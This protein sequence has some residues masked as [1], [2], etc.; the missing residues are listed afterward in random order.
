MIKRIYYFTLFFLLIFPLLLSAQTSPEEF[1]GHKVGADCKLADYNQ[2][3]AY[4]QTL[5]KESG[6]IKVLTIGKTTLN[7]PMIMAVITS[8]ENMANLDTYRGINKKLR[9]ARDLTPDDASRLAK[10]GK[11]TVFITCNLH[12]TEIGSSQMAMEFAYKL[13]TGKT[14]FDADK[15]LEDVIILIAP[16]INPDGQQMVTDWY[17]KY[18]GT[19]YEGGRMP[20]LYQHYAGHDN[21]RDWFMLNLAET[22]AVTKVL[23]QDW[24]P[25]IHIDQH[26]MGATGARLWIPPFAN[27]PN[28]NVHPLI[29]R[30]VAL[31]GMNMAYDL[32]KN[33][34]KGVQYGSEFAGWWDGACDNTPWFHNTICLLSEAASV[35]VASPIN[36]DISEISESYLEKSM[37]FPDP[38][39]GG[40]WR[41]RDIV[42]YELTLSMSLIKTAYLYKKELLYDF[43]KMGKDSI[44]KGGEGLPFAFVISK[45][46]NDYPTT[47]RMLDTLMYAGVEINQA[48]EDF[49][50]GDKVYPAG[51]FV[52]LMSQPYR[53][54][55]QALLE[56]QNHPE[57]KRQYP[58]GPF[59]SLLYDNAGWTLPLQMGVKCDQINNPFKANL[60]KLDKIPS[61]SITPPPETASFVILDSRLNNSY[62]VVFALFQENAEIYRSQDIIKGEGFET[63]AGSFIIKN[64]PQVQKALPDL[65]E[66][67]Q[68]KA[69]TLK[70]IAEIPKAPVKRYRVGLYQSWRS[71]MD[72]GWTRYVFDDLGIPF[73]TLHNKDFKGTKKVNLKTK[74][75]VIVFSDESADIIKL[76]K[77]NPTSRY[78]RYYRK[79]PPKYEGGIG[80]E[81]VEALK[82]FV[83]QGGI[84]VTLNSACGLAFNEFQVPAGNAIENIDRSK[85]F[86]PGSILKVKVDNK[87]PIGY[88]MPSEAAIMFYESRA[89]STRVP[90]QGWD[91]KVVARFPENDILL[92]GWLTGEDVIAR[93][94]AVVDIQR[95]KGHIILIGFPCQHRAQSHGTYKFLLNALLYPEIN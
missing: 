10:E 90:P 47:L 18:V 41:M 15:V 82:T 48:K 35:K 61:P 72:E 26:E 67:W 83:E 64:T 71:N 36:I 84:L 25:Q 56:K 30:G 88:G 1:L 31:F 38:W 70:D 93:K 91:R 54:Y 46:Q 34:F 27:P 51:S 24:V 68:V 87:T 23:Y 49:I 7:K 58:N 14:P 11:V 75:D 74:F 12:A 43:Y 39:P 79:P 3:Q 52:I 9:D 60:T 2:I 86:C 76:G 73:T 85:F 62:S 65:L 55:A 59:T 89:L 21:N 8:E 94:A 63:A 22:K 20:W 33:G 32:Q 19:K 50:V 69:D 28:P 17:R 78:A 92:S 42:D 45:K 95:K 80:E 66:K 6:K 37:Q 4:F 13:V 40:L 44:E 16:T 29:W 77:P 53:P 81:G 57:P 5:A